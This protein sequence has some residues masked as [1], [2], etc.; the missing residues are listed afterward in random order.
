MSYQHPAQSGPPAD[1]HRGLRL[2]ALTAVVVGLLLLAAAAF[3]L[4]YSGIHAV[5][6]SSGVSPRLARLYPPIFDAMLV[7]ACAAVLSLRGAG[8]PSRCYAWLSLLALFAAAAGAD[9]LHATG[10]KLPHKPAAATAAIIPWALV[11]VGFGLLL[12]MLRQARLRRATATPE[13]VSLQRSGHV[14]V[15]SGLRDRRADAQEVQVGIHDLVGTAAPGAGTVPTAPAS[16]GTDLASPSAA[17]ASGTTDLDDPAGDPALDLVIDS[18][19]GQDDPASDEGSA[20][21][22]PEPDEQ[23]AG[24][25]G[26]RVDD[27]RSASAF[28]PAP[29]MPVEAGTGNSAARSEPDDADGAFLGS[30]AKGEPPTQ[31][32]PYPGRTPE[33]TFEPEAQATPE[34]AS[35]SEAAPDLEPASQPEPEAAAEPQHA[36]SPDSQ[37]VPPPGPVPGS[38]PQPTRQ[39]R[40][41][42]GN[43]SEAAVPSRPAPPA[44]DNSDADP[45]PE[46]EP[47]PPQF[48]RMRSSPV[49]PEA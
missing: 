15:R 42:P 12:C 32:P 48:E 40:R 17:Q 49:P 39:T 30:V 3:M 13:R 19:P 34:T 45:A 41:K 36:S 46:K 31:V 5:A 33:A 38:D 37:L 35:A 6:L 4:S 23:P 43:P 18:D 2:F 20:W 11:L 7:I 24:N 25:G 22:P 1:S 10:T 9:M 16:S 8:L 26:Q 21:F 47:A 44:A 14:E 29:T 27:E 28:S